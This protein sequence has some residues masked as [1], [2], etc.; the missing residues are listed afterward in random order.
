MLPVTYQPGVGEPAAGWSVTLI[1]G[2]S[3]G[4]QRIQYRADWAC[5]LVASTITAWF[6]LRVT[7]VDCE[8]L[9]CV[10]T[11]ATRRTEPAG[12]AVVSIVTAF[13]PAQARLLR[14]LRLTTMFTSMNA[15]LLMGLWRWLRGGQKGVWQRTP[16][17][18]GMNGAVR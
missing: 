9:G 12:T 2:K 10:A 8:G 6:S 7:G 17:L 5:A 3:C 16:R 11:G 4:R 1:G 15:A 13:V 14:P 18:T